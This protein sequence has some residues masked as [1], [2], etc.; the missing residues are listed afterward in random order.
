[1]TR[2][3]TTRR[4]LAAP[5]PT[6]A[7]AA[8]DRAVLERAVASVIARCRALPEWAEVTAAGI[9][10]AGPIDLAAGTVAPINLPAVHG[11]AL[12]DLVR[13]ESGL[14]DVTLRLDGTCIALA[15]AWLGA[16]QGVDDAIVF[17]VYEGKQ[18]G[19]AGHAGLLRGEA[20]QGVLVDL[21]LALL[22][23]EVVAQRGHRSHVDA[24]VVRQYYGGGLGE[25]RL[26]LGDLL[27][28]DVP[29]HVWTPVSAG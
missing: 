8:S 7:A 28:L 25:L 16:A 9:G 21:V 4:R 5:R 13:R 12:V 23:A 26:E 11:L 17:D 15:E 18:V 29:V 27:L 2:T 24:A 6:G 20:G 22:L 1:M 10:S 14:A 3:T 19:E